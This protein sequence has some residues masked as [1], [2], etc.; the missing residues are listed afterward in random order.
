MA[1]RKVPLS[2][3]SKPTSSPHL[4]TL[5]VFLVGGPVSKEFGGKVMSRKVQ[6]RGDQTLHDLHL[7]IF[8]AYDQFEQYASF[9]YSLTHPGS[10]DER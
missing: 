1:K 8:K 9:L 3:T 5:E 10:M 2:R 6:I 4:Y 7:A